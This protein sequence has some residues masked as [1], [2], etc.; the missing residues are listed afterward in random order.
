M[1]VITFKAEEDLLLKLDLYAMNKRTPRSEII[2][3][4]LRIYLEAAGG[5]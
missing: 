3:D 5:I 1:R 4:A 2:R